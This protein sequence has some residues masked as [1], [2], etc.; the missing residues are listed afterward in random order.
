MGSVHFIPRKISFSCGKIHGDWYELF[1]ESSYS[2]IGDGEN[3]HVE[4]GNDE[5]RLEE[6]LELARKYYFDDEGSLKTF[7]NLIEHV[8]EHGYGIVMIG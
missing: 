7:I 1:E 8:R 3:C 2:I 4:I 5:E 6:L